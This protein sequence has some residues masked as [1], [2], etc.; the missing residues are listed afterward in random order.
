[1]FMSLNSSPQPEPKHPYPHQNQEHLHWAKL[2]LVRMLTEVNGYEAVK[3]WWSYVN[4]INQR[5][6]FSLVPIT[7]VS[8]L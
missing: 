3:L 5:G 8:E 7:L 6:K 2:G 4:D 1:M